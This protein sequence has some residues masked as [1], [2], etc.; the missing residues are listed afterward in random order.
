MKNKKILNI[1]LIIFILLIGGIITFLKISDNKIK[2]PNSQEEKTNPTTKPEEKPAEEILTNEEIIKSVDIYEKE[3]YEFIVKEDTGNNREVQRKNI[4][5]G[6][7]DMTFEVDA[8]TGE[9]KI[10]NID[11]QIAPSGGGAAGE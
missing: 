4:E 6:E 7:V 10:K 5:T 8:K 9:A 1:V 2:N 11:S 3:G